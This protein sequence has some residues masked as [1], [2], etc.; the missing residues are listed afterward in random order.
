ME[1]GVYQLSIYLDY[2]LCDGFKDPPRDWFIK[3]NAQGKYQKEGLLGTLDEYL[4]Q[5]L[6]KN[7][8]HLKINVTQAEMNTTLAGMPSVIAFDIKTKF[9]QETLV[10][11]SLPTT[12]GLDLLGGQMTRGGPIS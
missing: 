7:G 3:G 10:P 1:P 12:C 9:A 2:S 6:L 4:R 8:S 11:Y 5:P